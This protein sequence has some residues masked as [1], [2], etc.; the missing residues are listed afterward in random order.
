LVKIDKTLLHSSLSYIN[1][2]SKKEKNEAL[3]G[4]VADGMLRLWQPGFVRVWDAIPVDESEP[5][6]F[7]VK[8]DKFAQIVNSCNS[9]VISMSVKDKKLHISFGKSRVRLPFYESVEQ[10]VSAPPDIVSRILVGADFIQALS[11]GLSFL[12]KTEHAPALTCFYI[13]PLSPG[14][15]RVIAS[16]AM[17]MFV[18]D[19]EYDDAQHFEPFLF[20]KECGLF[21]TRAFSRAKEI[22]IGLTERG[23][24][25]L[26]E[27]GSEKVV[28]SPPYS[29][30]YPNM[31]KL[32]DGSFD[33]LFRANKKELQNM[34]QLVN[35]TSEMKEIRLSQVN[36][37]LELHA[38][39]SQI[40]TDLVLND[41]QILEEFPDIHFNAEFF[42]ICLAAM[43]GD[44]VVISNSKEEDKEKSYRIENE[45]RSQSYCLVQAVFS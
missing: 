19:I 10:E 1:A 39:K 38:T 33:K 14:L 30:S 34:T 22:S 16:D 15:L 5:M 43:D 18:A 40:E 3:V 21:M 24:L 36:S 28:V 26:S 8:C 13:S 27:V 11:K 32:I 37:S 44:A 25:V 20:P 12:A 35:I 7:T 4:Q 17:K 2:N 29:G 31:S 41:V 9:N 42:S 45:E 23:I 6:F